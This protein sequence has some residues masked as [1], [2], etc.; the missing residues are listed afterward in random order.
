MFFHLFQYCMSNEL[1]HFFSQAM[2]LDPMNPRG[3]PNSSTGRNSSVNTSP[4]ASTPGN[5]TKLQLFL[6]TVVFHDLQLCN[7]FWWYIQ[8][9]LYQ[10]LLFLHQLTHNMTT[11]CSLN[12]EFST[13][14][15]KAQFR[16]SNKNKTKTIVHKINWT[17]K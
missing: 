2:S 6:R 4:S 12:Y 13:W 1:S 8:V 9:N 10:K 5:L 16:M 17:C 3:I 7:T 15:L 14:E 11:D